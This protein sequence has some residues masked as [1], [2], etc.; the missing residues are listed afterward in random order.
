MTLPKQIP[1]AAR[2][3]ASTSDSVRWQRVNA[4]PFEYCIQQGRFGDEFVKLLDGSCLRRTFVP[5]PLFGAW[6]NQDGE[7]V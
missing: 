4:E 2:V 5:S 3:I 6:L 1:P 7:A